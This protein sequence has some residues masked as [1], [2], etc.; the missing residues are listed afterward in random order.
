MTGRAGGPGTFRT[1]TWFLISRT[2]CT[3]IIYYLQFYFC[4]RLLYGLLLFTQKTQ[5]SKTTMREKTILRAFSTVLAF[6]TILQQ[7]VCG[8]KVVCLY[9]GG[10]VCLR[11]IKCIITIVVNTN[12]IFI[13]LVVVV[14][15]ARVVIRILLDII[16]IYG[17]SYFIYD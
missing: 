6:Y 2:I 3:F 12:L 4:V 16:F 15:I 17:C 14:I 11:W 5:Y 10:L 8:R 7:K 9:R 1:P 13:R